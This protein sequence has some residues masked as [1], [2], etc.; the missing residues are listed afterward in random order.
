MIPKDFP[1]LGVITIVIDVTSELGKHGSFPSVFCIQPRPD[2]R[3]NIG[4]REWAG[5]G[6]V[7]ALFAPIENETILWSNVVRHDGM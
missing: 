5:K 3:D 1:S 4:N 7:V 2:Q 6:D